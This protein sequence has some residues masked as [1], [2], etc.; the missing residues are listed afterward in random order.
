MKYLDIVM[1][2]LWDGKFNLHNSGIRFTVYMTSCI[3]ITVTGRRLIKY[4]AKLLKEER[5]GLFKSRKEK[6]RFL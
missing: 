5:G 1:D 4:N 3:S 6:I 2:F